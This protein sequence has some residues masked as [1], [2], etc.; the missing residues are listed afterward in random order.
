MLFS[1]LF[2][3]LKKDLLIFWQ[4]NTRFNDWIL[5]YLPSPTLTHF[6]QKQKFSSQ[7]ILFSFF[8]YS[9][10]NGR[11]L[12]FFF[13]LCADVFWTGS[14]NFDSVIK[15]IT[16]ACSYYWWPSIASRSQGCQKG[17]TAYCRL[18]FDQVV[19]CVIFQWDDLKVLFVSLSFLS[20]V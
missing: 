13:C 14:F 1:G 17:R 20:R 5:F 7:F 11:R 2:L 8:S 3:S 9:V 18:A 12:G 4:Y 15:N 10:W 19:L 16:S 6:S